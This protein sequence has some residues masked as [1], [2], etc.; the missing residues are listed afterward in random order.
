[1]TEAV[2]LRLSKTESKEP[3]CCLQIHPLDNRVILVGTYS[4]RDDG[5]RDGTI[6]IYTIGEDS[7]FHHR[8]EHKVGSAVLDIKFSSSDPNILFTAHST[9]NVIIWNFDLDK[10]SLAESKDIHIFD[11][12][13]LV[14]SI[15]SCPFDP[16][17]LQVTGTNGETVILDLRDFSTKVLNTKHSLECWTGGFGGL[18]NLQHVVYSGGDDAKLIAHDLRTGD[19]FWSSNQRHHDAGVVSI[20]SPLNNWNSNNPNHIWTGSYDD[21]LRILDLRI[22][23]DNPELFSG[24]IPKVCK[25]ENLRGGVWRLIPSPKENDDRVM[26]CCMYDGARIVQPTLTGFE[27]SRYFKGDHVSMCYGGDWATQADFIITS[28]FYDKVIQ[29]WSPDKLQ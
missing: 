12:D 9:G 26:S 21:N 22:S 14:T 5:S 16:N 24:L 17:I 7:K 10:L 18:G 15:F 13:I 25:S 19:S 2:S 29:M 8:R 28:S 20:L 1:M 4:L 6:D 3:P 23:R 11:S 27:V